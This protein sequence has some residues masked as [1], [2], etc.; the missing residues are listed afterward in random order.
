MPDQT[1]TSRIYVLIAVTC[2][3]FGYKRD[4]PSTIKTENLPVITEKGS[5]FP[6]ED[7][8][9]RKMHWLI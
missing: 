4:D 7:G 2:S 8:L 9:V 6:D 3:G 5:E 1:I